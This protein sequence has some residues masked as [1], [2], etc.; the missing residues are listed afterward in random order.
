MSDAV[1]PSPV[2]IRGELSD[3]PGRGLWL[4]KWLLIIPHIVVLVFLAA[5]AVFCTVA[6]FFAI[7]FTGRY[8]RGLFDFTVGVL[9]WGWRV[10]FYSYGALATDRYPPFSLKSMDDYPA[11]LHI[12]YPEALSRWKP[13][14]K[15]LFA[16]PHYLI[17]AALAGCGGGSDGGAYFIGLLGALVIIVA[18]LLLFTENYHRDLYRLIMGIHRW[19]YRVCAYVGLLT[20]E[21]P[22]FRLMDDR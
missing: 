1:R 8:P 20:D 18:V 19:K 3:P 4:V 17:L 12:A 21:Y 22:H 14:V 10:E 13:L 11:D 16:F 15:W 6:A 7:L 9:R 5:A 2:T